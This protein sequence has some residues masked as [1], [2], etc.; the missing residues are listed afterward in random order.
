M[1]EATVLFELHEPPQ[2]CPGGVCG[3]DALAAMVEVHETLQRIAHEH[4]GQLVV[5]RY[6]FPK[7]LATVADPAQRA[8]WSAWQ[9]GELLPVTCC[10]GQVVKTGSYPTYAEL[11]AWADAG[12]LPAGETP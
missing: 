6:V 4:R 3:P 2:C 7:D 12:R 11:L 9:A 1:A 5:R 8:Q 10:G